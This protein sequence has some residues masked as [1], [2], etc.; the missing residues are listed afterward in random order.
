MYLHLYLE[1]QFSGKLTLKSI[2]SCPS[3]VVCL[4]LSRERL[5]RLRSRDLRAEP[6]LPM[7]YWSLRKNKSMIESGAAGNQKMDA[8]YIQ[9]A[10]F[11]GSNILRKST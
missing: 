4:S 1:L 10:S 3:K 2:L 11:I 5:S 8:I 7:I 6:L 9:F